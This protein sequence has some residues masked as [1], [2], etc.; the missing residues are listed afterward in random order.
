MNQ[1]DEN[2]GFVD[3]YLFTTAAKN[4]DLLDFELP[5]STGGLS[6]QMARLS[7][8]QMISSNIDN[9]PMIDMFFIYSA[10]NHELLTSQVIG[11]SVADRNRITTHLSELLQ[12]AQALSA[13]NN[14]E[15][16]PFNRQ[17]DHFFLHVIRT[18]QVYIGA[19]VS[20]D[21]LMKPIATLDLGQGGLAYF[22]ASNGE[23]IGDHS[24]GFKI[25]TDGDQGYLFAKQR[26]VSGE[27]E[28]VAAIKDS[29]VV[30][31]LPVIY[32]LTSAMPYIAILVFLLYLYLLRKMIVRPV[33]RIVSA[34]KQIYNGN[35]GARIPTHAITREFELMNWTF[36]QMATQ[37]KELKID[38]YEEKLSTQRAELKHLQLQ[39]NPHFFLNSLN[40]INSLALIKNYKLISEMSISL[41]HYFRFMFRS[42]HRF[43]QLREEIEH[44]RNYLKIQELRFPDT[45][46]YAFAI[47]SSAERM[48]VPPL[49]FQ[50]FIENT[51]KHAVTLDDPIHI[52]L[53][54]R[55]L[56]SPAGRFVHMTIKDSGEG[57][58]DIVLRKLEAN[59]SLETEEG[60]HIGIGNIKRR[61][62][63]LY[64]GEASIRFC[65]EDGARVDIVL[66]FIEKEEHHVSSAHSR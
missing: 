47:D 31:N 32:F 42:N 44:C 56:E 62:Q 37:I 15:W 54:V 6:Y 65:N 39:I 3:K 60:E 1:I 41:V 5:E 26:S 57:F 4:L 27:F 33:H 22:A 23:V 10:P 12:D 59:E 66:P 61:L 43:V 63:Y 30:E 17:N 2:L 11:S 9:Y 38:L 48:L 51:I 20:I 25:P 40:I 34:M 52:D 19:M 13:F 55:L 58:D 14:M 18:G 24:N 16:Y 46:T 21:R 36:N 8:N 45:L 29:E 49:I 64:Q 35:L 7:L 28:L 53:Q 50:C